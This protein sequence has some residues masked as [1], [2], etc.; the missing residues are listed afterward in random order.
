MLI[1]TLVNCGGIIVGC[2]VGLLFGSKFRPRFQKIAM[3][4]LG[5]TSLVIGLKMA[6]QVQSILVLGS[7]LVLG[8]LLGEALDIE[9]RLERWGEHLKKV[10]RST[11]PHLV[12]GFVTT[13]LL[14]C[15]GSMAIIG[16]IEEGIKG[17]SSLLYTKALLDGITS[18]ILSSTMGIGVLFSSISVLLYQGCITLAASWVSSALTDQIITEISATGGLLIVGIALNVLEI[19]KIK[20]GNLLPAMVFVAIFTI[21]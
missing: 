7:S 17:D 1:G 21:F 19:M 13:T 12:N 11:H 10:T 15:V 18:I 3:Q 2:I 4:G 8:G 5:L 6:L 9:K 16:P 14:F 20:I